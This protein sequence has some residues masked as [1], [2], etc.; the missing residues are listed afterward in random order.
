MTE[1]YCCP[2]CSREIL[3]AAEVLPLKKFSQFVLISPMAPPE[4]AEGE[5]AGDGLVTEDAEGEPAADDA[6]GLAVVPLEL[7]L[8]AAVMKARPITGASKIR[9]ASTRDRIGAPPCR[10]QSLMLC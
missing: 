5:P 8:H 3:V 1:A 2:F 9:R 7:L 4:L 10:S 6:G